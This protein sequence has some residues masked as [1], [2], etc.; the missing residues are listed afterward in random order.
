MSN[1]KCKCCSKQLVEGCESSWDG[2]LLYE[3]LVCVNDE[4][5]KPSEIILSIKIN[6]EV[7]H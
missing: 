4:C 5:A 7:E 2:E 3:T 6:R 1:P